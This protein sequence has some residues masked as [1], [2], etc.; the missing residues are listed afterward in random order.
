[1]R[2]AVKLGK[3]ELIW[4][5]KFRTLLNRYFQHLTIRGPSHTRNTRVWYRPQAC[6]VGAQGGWSGWQCYL[7]TVTLAGQQ[8]EIPATREARPAKERRSCWILTIFNR[9][10]IVTVMLHKGAVGVK[11]QRSVGW[12]LTTKKNDDRQGSG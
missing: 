2:K 7:G 12:P 9:H 8:E 6:A 5:V 4:T 3:D 10:W 1:M 11:W